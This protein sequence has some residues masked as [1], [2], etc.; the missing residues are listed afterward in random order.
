L[1][2]TTKLPIAGVESA[3]K[4]LNPSLPANHLMERTDAR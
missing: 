3:K 4:V 2:D 1:L